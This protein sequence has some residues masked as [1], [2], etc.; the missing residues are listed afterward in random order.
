MGSSQRAN[1]IEGSRDIAHCVRILDMFPLPDPSGVLCPSEDGTEAD[2]RDAALLLERLGP[3]LQRWQLA[4]ADPKLPL[5]TVKPIIR[6]VLLAL[7]YLHTEMKLSYL[8]LTLDNI[9]LG[10]QQTAEELAAD[11]PLKDSTVKLVS[12][13][14]GAPS[15][16]AWKHSFDDGHYH[17]LSSNNISTPE[18]C[19]MHYS[20]SAGPADAHD[21]WAVGIAASRLLFNQDLSSLAAVPSS[22]SPDSHELAKT[23]FVKCRNPLDDEI[24]NYASLD[25]TAGWP[26]HFAT[27]GD[28]SPEYEGASRFPFHL[29]GV[30]RM[31]NIRERVEA[32]QLIPDS[33]LD[34]LVSF[35][36]ACWTLN[37]FKRPGAKELLAHEW[38]SG[39]E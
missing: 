2:S 1:G 20:E 18:H 14:W 6:Q 19:F 23:P 3:S 17:P 10:R 38:L 33:D 25:P 31:S 22:R 35:L 9:L 11:N 16:R 7:D 28:P 34:S 30:S 12:F 27:S 39:V 32:T 15:C 36:R 21:I 37:P 13:G 4:R 29:P 26:K 5:G 24:V 8:A